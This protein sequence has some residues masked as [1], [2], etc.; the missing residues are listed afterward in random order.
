M[1][2]FEKYSIHNECHKSEHRDNKIDRKVD[3]SIHESSENRNYYRYHTLDSSHHTKDFS[4]ISLV[5]C[6]WSDCSKSCQATWYT[7]DTK[8]V[9]YGENNEIISCKSHTKITYCYK[10]YTNLECLDI[11]KS[12]DEFS[13]RICLVKYQKWTSKCEIISN[14]ISSEMKH[15]NEI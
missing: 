14:F 7:K 3:D 15:I 1:D 13:D 6:I 4:L 9:N 11:T 5:N 10:G 8:K 2:V 12:F